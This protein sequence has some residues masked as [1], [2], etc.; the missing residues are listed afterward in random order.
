[1]NNALGTQKTGTWLNICYEKEVIHII[2]F[3]VNQKS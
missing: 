1:M 2:D 3:L